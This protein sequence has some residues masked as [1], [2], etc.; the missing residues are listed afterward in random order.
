MIEQ[1]DNILAKPVDL[2]ATASKRGLAMAVTVIS[3]NSEILRE[4]RH[5][6]VPHGKIRSQGIREYE[7]RRFLLAVETIVNLAAFYGCK[8]H[9]FFALQMLEQDERPEL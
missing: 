5:L 9:L 2:E 7:H 3:Q 8:W 1:P 6:R 4:S